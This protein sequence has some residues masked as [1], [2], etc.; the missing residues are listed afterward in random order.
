MLKTL[1]V[2]LAL[3]FILYTS[4]QIRNAAPLAQAQTMSND[5]YIIKMQGFNAI[6]GVT[7]GKDYELRSTVGDLSPIVGEGVNFKV[8]T[9][10][11]NLA[12]NLPFSILLSSNLVN[13]GIISPTNPIIRT[14]DLTMNSLTAYGYSVIV[15][16]NEPLTIIPPIESNPAA[17]SKTFIPD[18]TC[19]NGQCGVENATQ[20]TNA[21]TY[22]FGYRCDNLA[23]ADCDSSFIKTNSYKHFPDLASND[24]PVSIMAG[25]GSNNKVAR[26]S[27][28]INISGNQTQGA[29]SNIV[30][31]IAIPSF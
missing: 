9:G 17:A 22:G 16:E 19:D 21:L 12:S 6:S 3:I 8:K 5:N 25:I 18:T 2:S 1:R 29:Y 26:I 31:Y 13:F 4:Y 24:N 28:K 15:F 23:G 11:E 10:F 20:W 7:S 27:Y 14:V 30:T